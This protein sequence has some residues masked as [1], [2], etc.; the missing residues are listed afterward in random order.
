MY[1]NIVLIFVKHHLIICGQACCWPSWRSAGPFL[2]LTQWRCPSARGRSP[3]VTRTL[4]FASRCFSQRWLCAMPSRTKST[5]TRVSIRKVRRGRKKEIYFT[6]LVYCMCTN[7][8]DFLQKEKS[9][10]V[11]YLF[12]PFYSFLF[13]LS[14]T[15]YTLLPTTHVFVWVTLS[16]PVSAHPSLIV[17]FPLCCVIKDLFLHM[18]SLVG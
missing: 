11:S 16:I 14:F 18:E 2:R 10:K 3:L 5:W 17:S 1:T 9:S 8:F 4:S 6:Y 15:Y 7:T 13:F 12:F